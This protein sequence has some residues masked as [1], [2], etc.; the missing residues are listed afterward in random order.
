MAHRSPR[1]APPRAT[2]R[3]SAAAPLLAV[4]AALALL[5][6]VTGCQSGAPTAAGPPPPPPLPQGAELLTKAATAMEAVKSAQLSVQVDPALTTVPIRS[7]QGVLTA[8]G[9]AKGTATL[10]QGS[11]NAEFTFVIADQSIYLKGPTGGYQQ[12]PL[13]LAAGIYDPTAL[14]DPAR[15]VATLLRSANSAKT[16]A[17]E[18]V[19]GVPTYRV[20]ATLD[21]RAMSS[22][23]PGVTPPPE[24]PPTGT[25][26]LDQRTSR[27][28]KAT[29][30][31]TTAPGARPA[32]VTVALS[33][34]DEPVT[35]TPPS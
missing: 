1:T 22:V 29:L 5:V 33:H 19:D 14:L 3:R 31:V 34:F 10:S 26:W 15:G 2:A 25:V 27:M 30:L 24:S 32:P 20:H 6:T 7:A 17:A 4:L 16:E 23:V 28:V 9:Q 18:D 12:L 8:T 35:I 13:A 21:P 11:D